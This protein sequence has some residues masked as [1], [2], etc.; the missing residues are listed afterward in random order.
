MEKR[1]MKEKDDKDAAL[2]LL[3]YI[4]VDNKNLRELLLMKDPFQ[5]LSSQDY[6]WTDLY[7][8]KASFHIEDYMKAEAAKMQEQLRKKSEDILKRFEKCFLSAF[9]KKGDADFVKRMLDAD[10]P[11][12]FYD[13]IEQEKKLDYRYLMDINK[14]IYQEIKEEDET[15]RREKPGILGRRK[16]CVDDLFYSVDNFLQQRYE[17]YRYREI[18][19]IYQGILDILKS[20]ELSDKKEVIS[21]PATEMPATEIPVTEKEGISIIMKAIQ[22]KCLIIKKDQAILLKYDIIESIDYNEQSLTEILMLLS[23]VSAVIKEPSATEVYQMKK[24][25][26]YESLL[27]NE[28][29]MKAL[30]ENMEVVRKNRETLNRLQSLL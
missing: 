13:L 22:E 6:V 17:I 20:C 3:R 19:F 2:W 5:T 23:K 28:K 15:A 11:N 29:F 24:E 18:E 14:T 21:E 7:G 10:N 27:E 30:M 4:G 12:G 25:K 16:E 26:D 1:N 9:Q 8:K